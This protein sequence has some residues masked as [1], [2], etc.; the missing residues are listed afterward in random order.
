M[1]LYH[2][3][4]VDAQ[5]RCEFAMRWTKEDRKAAMPSSRSITSTSTVSLS[6]STMCYSMPE[7]IVCGIYHNPAKP[8][9][10]INQTRPQQFVDDK[11]LGRMI[12]AHQAPLGAGQDILNL[13]FLGYMV[14]CSKVPSTLRSRCGQGNR[15][16][17]RDDE[18]L[19]SFAGGTAAALVCVEP[20]RPDP[21]ARW[22]REGARKRA[23]L[24]DLGPFT[25]SVSNGVS[26]TGLDHLTLGTTPSRRCSLG[27]IY[28]ELPI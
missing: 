2:V 25:V 26:T 6:T 8:Q 27:L 19:V 24:P 3:G 9:F 28:R 11:S 22:C 15:K 21:H 10:T 23:S 12:L 5:V 14:R 16:W 4:S 20:M 18:S 13:W 1:G 17:C 7:H